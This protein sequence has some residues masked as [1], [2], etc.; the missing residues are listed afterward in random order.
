MFSLKIRFVWSESWYFHIKWVEIF[1]VITFDFIRFHTNCCL[2][3]RFFCFNI[4]SYFIA[5]DSFPKELVIWHFK[6]RECIIVSIYFWWKL[7]RIFFELLDIFWEVDYLWLDM[8]Q[9]FNS[10]FKS[11]IQH[12]IIYFRCFFGYFKHGLDCRLKEIFSHNRLRWGSN[13]CGF[14]IYGDVISGSIYCINVGR[15]NKE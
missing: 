5:I 8:N 3:F 1:G 4:S 10:F 2:H 6:V 13:G 14:I 15:H 7:G 9:F 12:W 11:F